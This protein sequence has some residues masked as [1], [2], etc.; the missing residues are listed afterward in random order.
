MAAHLV[1]V[2]RGNVADGWSRLQWL[3]QSTHSSVASYPRS[4]KVPQESRLRMTSVL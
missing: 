2:R 1:E 4:S 3:N